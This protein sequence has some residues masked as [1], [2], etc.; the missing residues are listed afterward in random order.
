LKDDAMTG[1]ENRQKE[2]YCFV[3]DVAAAAAAAVST[4]HVRS[5]GTRQ[6]LR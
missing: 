1:L 4:P 5:H 3:E 6:P 2:E